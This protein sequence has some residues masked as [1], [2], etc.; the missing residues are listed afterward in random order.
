M[1]SDTDS[2]SQFIAANWPAPDGVIAGT[3]LNERGLKDLRLPGRPAWLHQVHGTD[4]V[5]VGDF[6]Q[7]PKADASV[8]RSM[9][10]VC[11][12]RT[13]DCLPV[14][15]VANDASEVAAAHAGWRGL[16]AGVLENTVAAM[17]SSPETVLAWF[18]PAISAQAF[19]VGAE[20]REAFLVTDSSASDCFAVNERG[21]W[22]AD[23]FALAR[24]RL[25]NCGVEA[26]FGGGLCTYSDSTRFCSYR[27]DPNCGRMISVVAISER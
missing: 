1:V 10:D 3:C 14:L 2:G 23:L 13:A 24:R 21:R 8:G 22:Q 4:V 7:P 27:K 5:V 16:A 12:I 18:G 6:D 15:F 9:G 17:R 20:V 11:V 19:E 25:K 26:V